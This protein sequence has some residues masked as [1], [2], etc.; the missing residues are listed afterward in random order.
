MRINLGGTDAFVAQ[1]GLNGPQIGATF[2]QSR[3]KTVAQGVGGNR[4]FE[5]G[6][7]SLSLDHDENHGAR[8]MPTTLT[9][10]HEILFSTL[11]FQVDTVGEPQF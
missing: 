8:E 3:G 6:F 7:L 11:D 5:A 9:Q 10:K 2:Q 4:L 1:H